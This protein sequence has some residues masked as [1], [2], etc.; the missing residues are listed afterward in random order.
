MFVRLTHFTLPP[1][2]VN[3]IKKVYYEDIA[4]V[5][6]QQAGIVNVLLLEPLEDSDEFISCTIWNSESDTKAFESGD[7]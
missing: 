5:I 1:E 4:P 7:D 2:K 6:K 3:E